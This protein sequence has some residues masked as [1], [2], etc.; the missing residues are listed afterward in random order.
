VKAERYLVLPFI[1]LPTFFLVVISV[2]PLVY[3]LFLS[4]FSG[5]LDKFI[6]LKNYS[7][8]LADSRFYDSF[9]VTLL[10]TTI[11]VGS[12]VLLGLVLSG[13]LALFSVERKSLWQTLYIVP[14]AIPP[15]VSGVIWKIVYHPSFGP[16]SLLGLIGLPVPD[17]IGQPNVAIF[18]VSVINIWMWTPFAFLVFYSG[19]GAVPQEQIEAGLVD[20]ASKLQIFRRVVLPSLRTLILVVVFWRFVANLT[21]FDEIMGS[22]EG[23][24]GFSTTTLTIFAYKIGFKS[25]DMGYAASAA[26]YLLILTAVVG[27]SLFRRLGLLTE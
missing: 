9:Y 18:A 1:V 14:L 2:Y 26:V 11:T 27:S 24:P 5:L 8:M 6:G 10:F 17:P 15:V 25:W 19:I 23:G 16:L 3:S 21:A 12:E 20:G 22:T 13:C 4:L 7:D